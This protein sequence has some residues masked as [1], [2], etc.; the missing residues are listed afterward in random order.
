MKDYEES[1][2]VILRAE[3]SALD[4][5]GEGT[6]LRNVCKGLSKYTLL[7]SKKEKTS[8]YSVQLMTAGHSIVYK[9]LHY[10]AH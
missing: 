5:G 10:I 1:A 2:V 6:F 3:E 9:L 8:T 4:P 7:Y